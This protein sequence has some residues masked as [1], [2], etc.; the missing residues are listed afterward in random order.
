[1][2]ENQKNK[3]ARTTPKASKSTDGM[4][5]TFNAGR[6]LLFRIS[7]NFLSHNFV[8][9]LNLIYIDSAKAYQNCCAK[10]T[11]FIHRCVIFSKEII[12]CCIGL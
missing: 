1:M 3:G 11:V 2:V 8:C 7:N 12:D 4:K 10:E 9:I 6:L 5:P